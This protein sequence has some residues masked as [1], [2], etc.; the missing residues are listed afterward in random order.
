[1]L[2]RIR[3]AITPKTRLTMT[4]QIGTTSDVISICKSNNN[5]TYTKKYTT[6]EAII[7]KGVYSYHS[8]VERFFPPSQ[9]A[10][11]YPILLPVISILKKEL[12]D[13]PNITKGVPTRIISKVNGMANHHKLTETIAGKIHKKPVTTFNEE[14]KL[15]RIFSR[16]LS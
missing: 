11:V 12:Q 3:P 15:S 10:P 7:A 6:Q 1:M 8:T 4:I 5:A 9:K 14:K 13:A 16:S 2:V